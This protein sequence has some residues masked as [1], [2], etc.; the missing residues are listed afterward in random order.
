MTGVHARVEPAPA[1]AP[2]PDPVAAGLAST[3][4]SLASASVNAALLAL[5]LA[6]DAQSLDGVRAEQQRRHAALAL[7]VQLDVA[8]AIRDMVRP[9]T[10]DEG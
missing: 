7:R 1:P 6:T 3:L 5:D 4:R 10:T 9:P 8:L 2:T